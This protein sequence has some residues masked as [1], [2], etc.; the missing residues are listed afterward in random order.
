MALILFDITDLIL[1]PG[2]EFFMTLLNRLI[3]M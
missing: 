2:V 1:T 3:F